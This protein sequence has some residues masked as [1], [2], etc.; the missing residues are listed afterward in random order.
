[1]L[2]SI[3]MYSTLHAVRRCKN[4]ST[5]RVYS[6]G[7][8]IDVRN[9]RQAAECLIEQICCP[10]V[11]TTCRSGLLAGE[12]TPSRHYGQVAG[13]LVGDRGEDGQTERKKKEKKRVE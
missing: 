4:N 5:D 12:M 2:H 9:T 6:Q 13:E 8:A 3:Y 7:T 10:L 11:R 1:M